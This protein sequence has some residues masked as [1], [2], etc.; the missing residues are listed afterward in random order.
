M[1]RKA[2]LFAL[3]VS[4]G[5]LLFAQQPVLAEKCENAKHSHINVLCSSHTNC[6]K[7]IRLKHKI[8]LQ[9]SDAFG[10]PI[11]G[12]ELWVTLDIIK[13]GSI[14]TVKVPL[15]NFQTDECSI[16]DP[17]CP[18]FVPGGYLYTS[19]GFLPE[20]LRPLGLEPESIVAASNNGLSPVF[21]FAQ[22]P[23]TLPQ[24]PAGFI[25]QITNA[26]AL[27]VQAAG[28]FGNVIAP[29]PQ[30]LMPCALTYFVDEKEK[31][32]KNEVLSNGATNGTEFTN[33]FFQDSYLRDSHVND[34]YAGV[35]AWAWIDNSMVADKKNGTTNCMVVVGKADSN[36]KLKLRDP[37]Q[38]TNL[39]PE[40]G[41]FDT[42]VAINRTDPNN[43]IVSY[44][45]DTFN[46][47]VS[48]V[49]CRAVTFD[50]GK[51]WPL[52]FDGVTPQLYNGPIGVPPIHVPSDARGV[53]S[54]KF[55]NIWYGASGAD[56]SQPSPP[57]NFFVSTD[58]GRS[59]SLVYT[60]QHPLNFIPGVSIF[61]YPQYCFGGLG[62]GSNTYGLWFIQDYFANG[63]DETPLIGFIPIHGP[64]SFGNPIQVNLTDFTNVAILPSI[65][66]SEEGRV[67]IQ[68]VPFVGYSYIA[69]IGTVFKSPGAIDSNYAGPWNIGM[70]NQL[71][72]QF[73]ISNTL[74]SPARG[75]FNAIQGSVFDDKRQ[76]L[77]AIV[78]NQVPDNSQNMDIF[79]VISRDNGMT[80]SSPIHIS[81]T[82][83]GNRGFASMALDTV[84]GNLVF[85][86][87]DGRNDK[88]F[89]S[90]EYFGAVLPAKTLDKLVNELP[91]SYPVFGIADQDGTPSATTGKKAHSMFKRHKQK[92][93]TKVTK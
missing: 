10:F 77:Y 23:A 41:L 63:F 13:N 84:T 24:P 47:P 18:T 87:Y 85:G 60:V 92:F 42:A 15:I 5:C 91:L 39:P 4:F 35:V 37:V 1:N 55:G 65:T 16:N 72:E 74:S 66:A 22:D 62:D 3:T 26:G 70:I 57:A 43:I 44:R 80:W 32:C 53:A 93:G 78:T 20:C 49:L 52:A 88:T 73:G 40:V 17:F 86:W 68:S 83:F 69:P 64:N 14:V 27:Q 12:T 75:Y 30:I 21:S 29:G 34:A 36:G 90:L 28:T 50:G 67:W 19:A 31:L 6:K 48:R 9:L 46:S 33:P 82:N 54:D 8:Q 38:L 25:V 89:K 59:F 51:T 56:N 71:A 76:A 79:F 81:N 61:D 7:S 11:P 45:V 58:Q 2:F